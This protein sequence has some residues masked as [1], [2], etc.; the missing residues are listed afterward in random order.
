MDVWALGIILYAL[1]IGKP[2]FECSTVDET[3]RRIRQGHFDFPKQ[4]PISSEAKSLIKG[5]LDANPKTRISLSQIRKHEFLFDSKVPVLMPAYTISIPPQN[6]YL[7]QW[8]GEKPAKLSIYPRKVSQG[9]EDSSCVGHRSGKEKL[10]RVLSCDKNIFKMSMADS[11]GSY[12]ELN[13]GVIFNTKM[14]NNLKEE[15]PFLSGRG[16]ALSWTNG[17]STDNSRQR[18]E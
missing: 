17:V 18:Y 15:I 12:S 2:P 7:K 4:I 8:V 1:L 16:P 6:S 5:L 10:N 11:S 13:R 14:R 3:Y 9:G